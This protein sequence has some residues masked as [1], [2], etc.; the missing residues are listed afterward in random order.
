MK[1]KPAKKSK[2]PVPKKWPWRIFKLA[3]AIGIVAS[4]FIAIYTFYLFIGIEDR[5]ASRRWSI[6]STVYSDITLLYPGERINKPLFL[7]KLS[8]LDYRS[9]DHTPKAKGEMQLEENRVTLFLND[10]KTPQQHR[11]G[12][13]VTILYDNK[14]IRNISR[15]DTKENLPL[16]ELEP[17][18]IMFFFGPQREKRQLVSIHD[19]PQHLVHAVLAAEDN[20]F[21]THHGVDPRGLLRA[22]WVN[23]RHGGFLQGGST[24]TQQLAKNYFLTPERTLTRKFKELLI[25]LLLEARFEKEEIIEI[26]LNEIYFGQKGSVSINGVGEA[27]SFYFGKPVNELTPPESSTLAGLIKGPNRYS[28]Y[29]DKERC[30]IRR[31]G[32]LKAMYDNKWISA[33]ELR[34]YQA[35]P[36]KTSGFRVSGKKAPYFV[37]YLSDQLTTLYSAGDLS[38]LGLS[39]YTTLD[40]QVQI[41]AEE[42]LENGL[43][44]LE[45]A[46]PKLRRKDPARK[47]Q[48]AVVVMQPK[49]GHILA[50]VGGRN[51]TESQFNRAAK[52]KRQ[53]GSLFKPF[54]ALAALDK[55]TPMTRLSNAPKTYRYDNKNWQPQN[56][57]PVRELDV[58]LRTAMQHSYNRAMVDLAMR[59]GLDHILDVIHP[60]GFTTPLQPYP[61]LALGPFEMIPLEIAR[62]YCAFAADGVLPYPLS[63]KE[64]M[65][66]EGKLLEQHHMNIERAISPEKAFL[67]TDLLRSVVEGGTAKSLRSRGIW[68]PVAAKTGT[69]ND[70]RDAWFV[71]YTPDILALIW[72]GFDNGDPIYASGGSAALPVWADLIRSIPQY[73][74]ERWFMVPPGVAQKEICRGSGM[75]ARPECPDTIKEYFL[76]ENAPRK[77]CTLH[78]SRPIL[79]QWFRRIEK[80]VE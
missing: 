10:M 59:T 33:A 23:L 11:E 49:T 36:V 58:S 2:K 24:L 70:F 54:V 80:L 55:F 72:V 52:A 76:T 1:K 79:E 66:E 6:P 57:E 73:V 48:G 34:K 25:A 64:T 61:S 46:N 65:D 28:P 18:N 29:V 47:L 42:A 27:A 53:P 12:F 32:V 16:L 3:L 67:V 39:I 9:V 75:L 38:S 20:R 63:L 5:F 78:E 35:Q 44:A 74:S 60:F 31:N 43:T 40:T 51:Y 4:V 19:V 69:T 37:D 56:F 45:N 15:M 50:M 30:R 7:D 8:R 77:E 22:V 17:E 21:F 14:S 26:Y 13:P 62:A 71:G 68:F 41:A